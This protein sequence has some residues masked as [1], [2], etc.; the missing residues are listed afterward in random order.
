MTATPIPRTIA[1][2]LYGDLDL[3]ALT[4][5]PEGRLPVKTWLVPEEKRQSSYGWIRKQKTQVFW[6]CPFIEESESMQ[7][8]KAATVEY[9]KLKIIFKE[10]PVGL[11]HGRMKPA[12]KSSVLQKFREGQYQILVATPVVE[13]G[14]DI[15]AASIMVIEAAERFGLAQLHQLRGRVGRGSQ[16]AY[17]LLFSTAETERLKAMENHHSGLELAEID[18]RLRGPGEVYGVSQHGLP[19]FR[20]ASY[21]DVDMMKRAKKHA[22]MALPRLPELP[23]LRSLVEKDKIGLIQPN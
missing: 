15:P 21:S 22:E 12:E 7:S 4:D 10:F 6:V 16:Q 1:L 11:L 13:V 2:A 17:C 19:S 23:L 3:S 20:I 14:I 9:E 18:L 5:M 8:V